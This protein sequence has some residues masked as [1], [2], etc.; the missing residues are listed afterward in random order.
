MLLKEYGAPNQE[1]KQRDA[2]ADPLTK[3]KCCFISTGFSID[4][5]RENRKKNADKMCGEKMIILFIS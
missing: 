5:K 1:I 4:S 2:H 3:R